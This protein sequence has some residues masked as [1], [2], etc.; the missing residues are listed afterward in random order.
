M[1]DLNDDPNFSIDH[2]IVLIGFTENGDWIV[3][4]SWSTGWGDGGFAIIDKDNNCGLT[5]YQEIL[6]VQFSSTP[7]PPPTMATITISMSDS[8]ADGWNNN[9]IKIDQGSLQSII[10]GS[11]F[12]AGSVDQATVEVEEGT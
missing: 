10:V 8:A 9:L 6:D 2:L 11:T 7:P 4:N 5:T 12:T 1:S 3:K